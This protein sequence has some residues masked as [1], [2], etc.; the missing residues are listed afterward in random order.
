MIAGTFTGTASSQKIIDADEYRDSITVQLQNGTAVSVAFGE[1]AVAGECAKLL[2]A[3]DSL[4][5]RGWLARKAVYVIGDG[6]AGCYQ[7]GDLTLNV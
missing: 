5:A 3:G 7:E 2:A 4:T 1:D 6:A